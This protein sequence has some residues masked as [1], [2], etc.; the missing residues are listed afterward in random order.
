MSTATLT[1]REATVDWDSKGFPPRGDPNP[2][3]LVLASALGDTRRGCIDNLRKDAVRRRRRI[4]VVEVTSFA[5][6]RNLVG[7]IEYGSVDK[8]VISP[9]DGTYSITESSSKEMFPHWVD[10]AFVPGI[11]FG[12]RET[13]GAAVAGLVARA[14]FRKSV[15]MVH[16]DVCVVG[17]YI[18][19]LSDAVMKRIPA[20]ASETILHD[21]RTISGYLGEVAVLEKTNTSEYILHGCPIKPEA[22]AHRGVRVAVRRASGA[23]YLSKRIVAHFP[24]RRA[25]VH[26]LHSQ[27]DPRLL[28]RWDAEEALEASRSQSPVVLQVLRW[29]PAPAGDSSTGLRVVARCADSGATSEKG[30]GSYEATFH[31]ANLTDNVEY[32]EFVVRDREATLSRLQRHAAA[33]KTYPGHT[34]ERCRVSATTAVGSKRRRSAGELE[35]EAV[36]LLAEA[37]RALAVAERKLAGSIARR[38]SGAVALTGVE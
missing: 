22:R 4:L 35:R 18:L 13:Q 12:T 10:P 11:K 9:D 28:A 32:R 7:E 15:W 8:I 33:S 16:F 34:S 37:K 27:L 36:D 14:F 31:V 24:P 26:G 20:D 6:C 19:A 30:S 1:L 5:Q 17:A 21:P 2:V 3:I 25:K 23:S 38:H 29:G